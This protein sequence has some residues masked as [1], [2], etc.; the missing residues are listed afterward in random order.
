MIGVDDLIPGFNERNSITVN[1][2]T[3]AE[4][5]LGKRVKA[6]AYINQVESEVR[7]LKDKLEEREVV[8]KR[9]SETTIAE[10]DEAL[11]TWAVKEAKKTDSNSVALT[12][13]TLTIVEPE[14][15]ATVNDNE[16]LLAWARTKNRLNELFE[17]TY[18]PKTDAISALLS[19]RPRG[20][21]TVPPGVTYVYT[22]KHITFS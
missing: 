4:A 8:Q 18:V 20:D 16:A 1:T 22:S 12:N 9:K 21:T 13:A 10:V 3:D 5:A 19:A 15:E 14:I 7:D 6:K 11:T 17:I 2:Y